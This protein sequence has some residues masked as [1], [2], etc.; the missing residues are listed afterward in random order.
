MVRKNNMQ[1]QFGQREF[2]SSAKEKDPE[3]DVLPLTLVM[4]SVRGLSGT[5]WCKKKR[6]TKW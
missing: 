5:G 2:A 3:L 1:V 6:T 4:G